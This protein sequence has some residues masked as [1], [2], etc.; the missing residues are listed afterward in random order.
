M[1]ASDCEALANNVQWADAV[2][3]V[4]LNVLLFISLMVIVG[5]LLVI[6]AVYSSAKLR[7][8]TNLFIVSLAFADLM[9]GLSVLPFSAVWE[10]YKVRPYFFFVPF[11]SAHIVLRMHTGPLH[12]MNHCK[13]LEKSSHL[14]YKYS[15][16][17]C[18]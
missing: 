6:A 4:V 11:L 10:V 17:R 7:T 1:N 15:T 12:A 16:Y 5:N 14:R 3:L 18:I 9:V 2:S 8:V 13:Y